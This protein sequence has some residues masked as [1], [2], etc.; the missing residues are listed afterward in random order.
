MFGHFT[1]LCMK[2]FKHVMYNP[3]FFVSINKYQCCPLNVWMMYIVVAE[4]KFWIMFSKMATSGVA[5][6]KIFS[7]E[8]FSYIFSKKAPCTFRPR[9]LKFFPKKS[10]LKK[11]LMFS[12][13]K[14]LIF[15]KGKPWK[16][17]IF[18]ETELSYTSRSNC[19]RIKNVL[20]FFL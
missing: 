16:I 13:K 18:Q 15:W 7:K 17:L 3:I 5:S 10:A 12:Q 1:T 9:P 11:F 6:E 4:L 14:P 19:P 2:G 20:Y 8:S